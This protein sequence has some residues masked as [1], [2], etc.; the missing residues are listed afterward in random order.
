MHPLLLE[1]GYWAN[2]LREL[3]LSRVSLVLIPRP[4][5]SSNG[6]EVDEF[7]VRAHDGI[8]LWG[9]RAR[10]RFGTSSARVRIVG[11]SDLPRIDS[12]AVLRG[13]AEFVFQEPAGRRLEDRVL[14]VLRVCHLA[15]EVG[16]SG[17]RVELVASPFRP[18]PDEF[19][20]A[21]QLLADETAARMPQ[22]PLDDSAGWPARN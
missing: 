5:L 14:D 2:R 6:I 18:A 15:G 9:L 8:R 16:P 11:P 4:E 21:T 12:A 22:P 13:E 3:R 7:R 1:S 19:L 10:S 20:I 17:A